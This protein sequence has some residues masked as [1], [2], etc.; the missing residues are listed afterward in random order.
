MKKNNKIIACIVII[1]LLFSMFLSGCFR[2]K[3]GDP[4]TQIRSMIHDGITRSYRVHI[5]S[6]FNEYSALVFVL[7]GG[8]GTGEH[9]EE[10]LTQYRFNDLAGQHG[11]I[12]VYPDGL[13][14]RWNDGRKENN[15]VTDV[16][17]VGFL[18]TLIDTLTT[19]FVIDEDHVFF[20]GISNGGQM[21]YRLA[22]ERTD[23]ITAIAPVV[24]SLHE[25]LYQNCSPSTPISVFLMAG[26]DDPLVPFH[27]GKIRIF[28][29]TFGTVIAMNETIQYWISVNN[30]STTPIETTLPDTNPSDGCTVTSYEYTEGEKDSRVLYYIINGGGHTW[31]DGGKYLTESLVGKICYDF[32]ACEHIWAFFQQEINS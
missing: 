11:F 16:D 15:P 31:P 25:R 13:E 6:T 10:E 30:C 24:S 19:E 29:Q 18:T 3:T 9:T 1:L 23:K 4:E 17:D 32:N 2:R 14:N 26:T 21:S 12:V 5:P 20:T 27:G 7:H 28:N 8:G 22:C